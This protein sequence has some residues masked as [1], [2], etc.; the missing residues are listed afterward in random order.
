MR[1]KS[2]T[3][4]QHIPYQAT[5][6]TRQRMLPIIFMRKKDF[7]PIPGPKDVMKFCKTN[8]VWLFFLKYSSISLKWF[9][10]R[11]G[12]GSFFQ[13]E[14]S[15][16]F[17]LFFFYRPL[18]INHL[19]RFDWVS[20]DSCDHIHTN[21]ESHS[22]HPLCFSIWYHCGHFGF[23]TCNVAP[24][25][26]MMVLVNFLNNWTIL[27]TWFRYKICLIVDMLDVIMVCD[28]L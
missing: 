12:R 13:N 28:I 1:G 26:R 19:G 14:G 6:R 23:F 17:K 15:H 20:P 18:N 3:G 8:W 25:I 10:G 2:P 27:G 9:E 7:L 21:A 22:P 24:F 4:L 11:Y 5:R 16:F